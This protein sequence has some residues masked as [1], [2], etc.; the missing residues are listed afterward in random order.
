MTLMML[1]GMRDVAAEV[2]LPVI[3]ERCHRLSYTTV[4]IYALNIF[5]EIG[6]LA[7]FID[8]TVLLYIAVMAI[9]GTLVLVSFNLSQIYSC[10]AKI[11][12]PG[13]DDESNRKSRFGFVN[14]FR[15]HEKEKQREYL[16]YK[17]EKLRKRADKNR[18]EP[19]NENK[20]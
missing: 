16:D 15:A 18:E 13:E 10:Y 20:K 1:I 14:A 12:M 5:L 2:G 17:M 7:S 11:C 6:Q 3:R 8:M 19:K 4:V 9:F